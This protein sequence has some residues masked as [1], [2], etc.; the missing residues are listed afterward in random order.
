MF[1]VL[2]KGSAGVQMAPGDCPSGTTLVLLDGLMQRQVGFVGEC[3]CL[4]DSVR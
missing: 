2:T 3:P 4:W 1:D